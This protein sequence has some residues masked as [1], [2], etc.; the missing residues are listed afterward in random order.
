[1]PDPAPLSYPSVPGCAAAVQG[2]TAAPRECGAVPVG[3][4]HHRYLY[5]TPRVRRLFVCSV[6]AAGHE[7]F[8]AMDDDARA[9]LARRRE[10]WRM[11]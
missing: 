4:V 7:G 9:E 1:M 5:P 3:T 8:R 11:S 2:A 10:K 6:H